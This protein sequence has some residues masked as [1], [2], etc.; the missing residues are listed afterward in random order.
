MVGS[1][2]TWDRCQV[3]DALF[4]QMRQLYLPSQRK[5]KGPEEIDWQSLRQMIFLQTFLPEH[6]DPSLALLFQNYKSSIFPDG[7]LNLLQPD[8]LPLLEMMVT[9]PFSEQEGKL[10]LKQAFDRQGIPQEHQEFFSARCYWEAPGKGM[11]I[12]WED[13]DVE[14]L[15]HELE[16]LKSQSLTIGGL[17]DLLNEAMTEYRVW[18]RTG[19][20]EEGF[21][22]KLVSWM[23]FMS[24]EHF[25]IFELLESAYEGRITMEKMLLGLIAEMGMVGVVKDLYMPQAC[26]H[27]QQ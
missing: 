22:E 6:I 21:Y 10:R 17:G 18:R 16:H 3:S 9:L 15:L 2:A 23:D 13:C 8:E 11:M 20:V 24:K 19:K 27:R 1:S 26:V 25:T 14:T 5:V 7:L 12:V 4:E